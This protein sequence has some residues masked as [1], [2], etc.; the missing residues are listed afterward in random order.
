MKAEGFASG[1]APTLYVSIADEDWH[2]SIRRV[3]GKTHNPFYDY[4]GKEVSASD[5]AKFLPNW[6]TLQ[7]TEIK[8]SPLDKSQS[9]AKDVDFRVTVQSVEGGAKTHKEVVEAFLAFM[10]GA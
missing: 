1:Q 4:R 7:W 3:D 10:G 5:I 8:D 9:C 2:F 6:R